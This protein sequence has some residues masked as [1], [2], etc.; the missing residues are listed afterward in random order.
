[1][2]NQGNE[3]L[4]VREHVVQTVCGSVPASELGFT[5]PHEHIMVDFGGAVTAG[6]HRYD[7][8]NVIEIMLPYLQAAAA[9]GVHTFFECT[10]NFLGRDPEIFRTLSERSGLN[11]VTNTG[12]YNNQYLPE[13][14]KTQN[15]E[16]LAEAWIAEFMDG[17]E[18]SGI[19]P[20]FIKTAVNP[21][22]TALDLKLIHAAALAHKETGLTIATHTC[23]ADAAQAIVRILNQYQVDP[24][25]WIFVHA[26]VEEDFS[27]VLA[28]AQT[29]IWIELDGL[30]WGGDEDHVHKLMAL[31]E[32]GY[33]DQILLS[34]DAGWYHIGEE[35]GGAV[36]P[37]TRLQAEFLP[38]LAARGVDSAMIDKITRLNPANAFGLR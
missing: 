22:P 4:V 24:S 37:Y 30:A 29:G 11:I 18:G 32:H 20:G 9:Q 14:A 36:I 25:R 12:L 27:R 5:L 19:K 23:T 34:Q 3:E 16:R 6:K 21:Q 35:A 2:N 26:H 13:Y 15:A 28:L 38:L 33:E 7:A 17:I 1:M 10:P 8:D 31:L